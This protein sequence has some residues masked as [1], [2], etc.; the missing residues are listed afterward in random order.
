MPAASPMPMR[1]RSLVRYQELRYQELKKGRNKNVSTLF[2]VSS[3]AVVGRLACLTVV[4]AL[5][6]FSVTPPPE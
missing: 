4:P 5:V 2:Y 1:C 3:Q 6:I